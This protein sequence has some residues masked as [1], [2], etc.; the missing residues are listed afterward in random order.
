MPHPKYW[1][2][3]VGNM[4]PTAFDPELRA[5]IWVQA[6]VGPP[7]VFSLFKYGVFASRPDGGY[8]LLAD[9]GEF[10]Y[11]VAASEDLRRVVLTSE[12]HLLPGDAARSE[13]LSI[14]ES[15]GS[16]LRLLDVDGGGALIS[17]CGL[18]SERDRCRCDAGLPPS[19]RP[20]CGPT[21]R[22]Y[23]AEAGQATEISAS[24]CTLADC[25]P[26]S[27]VDFLGNSADGS[28]AFLGTA[29]RLTDDDLNSDREPRSLRRR[30]RGSQAAL[31]RPSPARL[32]GDRSRRPR[33]LQG[34]VAGLLLRSGQLIP[35][36]GSEAGSTSTWPTP[37]ACASSPRPRKASNTPISPT[38]PSPP[39]AATRSSRRVPR[40]PP[41]TATNRSTSTATTPWP[42][43]SHRSRPAA[44]TPGTDRSASRCPAQRHRRHRPPRRLHHRGAAG[45]AGPER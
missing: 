11:F 14:Y 8:T 24:Q 31:R 15:T 5:S 25:G 32:D 37:P 29:E 36:Q 45:S 16:T 44:G 12:L 41:P 42:M 1:N 7:T 28:T 19:A 18:G 43:P 40:S 21:K 22:V 35:G 30:Q 13:G 17:T 20:G 34:R 27:D 9:G 26:A 38:S 3:S 4:G 23:M 6:P 10:G 33:A 2:N 39:T